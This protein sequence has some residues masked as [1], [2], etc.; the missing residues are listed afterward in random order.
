[1]RVWKALHQVSC[2]PSSDSFDEVGP[3]SLTCHGRQKK[4]LSSEVHGDVLWHVSYMS[5]VMKLC[6]SMCYAIVC[7]VCY[8]LYVS[9]CYMLAY[10][11]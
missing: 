6:G 5:S 9:V 3:E 1:M 10:V 8:V 2:S 11:V 4:S 7:V